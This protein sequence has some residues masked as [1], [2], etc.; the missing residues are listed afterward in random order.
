MPARNLRPSASV[1]PFPAR[2]LL[3]CSTAR[4]TPRCERD[5]SSQRLG[6][7]AS[8]RAQSARGHFQ[9]T[10]QQT[11]ITYAVGP[12]VLGTPAR[13]VSTPF[14]PAVRFAPDESVPR[15]TQA[16]RRTLV[17]RLT[18]SV[19]RSRRQSASRHPSQ[20]PRGSARAL[21]RA[22]KSARSRARPRPAPPPLG[23]SST[24]PQDR[25]PL[26]TFSMSECTALNALVLTCPGVQ[27]SK[28]KCSHKMP[29]QHV[30]S[31]T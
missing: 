3:P 25:V 9:R 17:P 20:Y 16:V 28:A 24:G 26:S 14:A 30:C 13:A 12:R 22:A 31:S 5:R 4:L 2:G 18:S 6:A 10:L 27:D 8:V 29:I 21:H 19:P 11:L 7:T 23:A 1:R 15:G